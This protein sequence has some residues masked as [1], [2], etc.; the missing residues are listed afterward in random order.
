MAFSLPELPYSY[1]ALAPYMSRETLGFHHDKHHLAYVNNGN[2]LMKGTEFE[3]RSLEDVVKS[4]YFGNPG[5]FNNAGQHY[6]HI[7]FWKWMKP[8]GGGNMVR[9]NGPIVTSHRHVLRS[10][11]L[12]GL[13]IAYGPIDFFRDDIAAGR[14]VQVL[15]DYELP[16]ATIYA[17]YPATRRLSAKVKAFN[18][19]MKVQ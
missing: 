1:D 2:N 5:L 14:L 7:H 6:N 4:S 8:A 3:S 9:V 17:V 12:R 13:G 16:R 11:A 19:F 15:P 10:A 18:D